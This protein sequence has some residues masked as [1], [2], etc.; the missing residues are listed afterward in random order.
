MSAPPINV[1]II[2]ASGYTGAELMRLLLGHS[3]VR[4]LCV[5]AERARGEAVAEQLPA[6]AGR[7]ELRFTAHDDRI[8]EDCQLVFAA[9]PEA[10]AMDRAVALL[11]QGKRIIDLSANFRLRDPGLWE[12]WYGR[13]HDYPELLEEAVYGLPE[14]N[15]E[16]IRKARLIANPG[17]YPT[18]VCL[19][20][21]PL[22]ESGHG[23]VQD[24]VI[25]AKSGISGAGRQLAATRLFCEVDGG[26][27]A[28]AA[29][30]HRHLPEIRQLLEERLQQPVQAVFVPHLLPVNRGMEAS[31]YVRAA[32]PQALPELPE[33][34]ALY[35]SYYQQQPFMQVLPAGSHPDIR[36]V[37]GSNVC[38]L[39][40]HR[41]ADG[42]RVVILSVLDNLL[43]GAAGQA[44]QNMNI[45]CGFPENTGLEALALAP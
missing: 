17:C 5:S 35:R 4:L 6:F 8:F 24:I 29:A 42:P 41:P 15:R 34:Q 16:Q 14:L 13:A 37:R 2:G 22:L 23:A 18:A 21:L 26:F 45:A 25:D 28:Y 7:T 9:A 19:G 12:R 30:G 44:L 38:Q 20:L 27:R 1:G 32:K 31:L 40:V 39:A 43:K 11:R 10:V 33:L 36:H 3:G